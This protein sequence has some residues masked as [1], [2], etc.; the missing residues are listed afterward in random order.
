MM[1]EPEVKHLQNSQITLIM[2]WIKSFSFLPYQSAQL[3]AHSCRKKRRIHAFLKGIGMKWNTNTVIINEFYQFSFWENLI[4]HFFLYHQKCKNQQ[5]HT[6]I[7][8]VQAKFHDFF[9]R[10]AWCI[11]EQSM[12]LESIKIK[13]VFEKK[14]E[15][16]ECC[17]LTFDR[18]GCSSCVNNVIAGRTCVNK[19]KHVVCDNQN[20][21]ALWNYIHRSLGYAW[22]HHKQDAT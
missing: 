20:T 5:R 18:A 22:Q 14:L 3:L 4:Y 7:Q 6:Y 11:S 10:T 21:W 12:A 1:F 2:F 17:I 13:V 15:D 19:Q 9:S 16:M 8:G